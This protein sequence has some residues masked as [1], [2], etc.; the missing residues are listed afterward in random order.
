MTYTIDFNGTQNGFDDTSTPASDDP[1]EA[2][3]FTRRYS[4]DVGKVL[5]SVRGN[6]ATYEFAGD[7]LYVRALI[8]SSRPHPNPGEHGEM[9]RAWVQPVQP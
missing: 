1:Q 3:K 7:E 6:T 5:M 9:E 2:D 8:T 4:D